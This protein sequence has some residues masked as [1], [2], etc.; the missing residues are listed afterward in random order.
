MSTLN[1]DKIFRAVSDEIAKLSRRV[2]RLER[3]TD[4][5]GKASLGGVAIEWTEDSTIRF[6]AF[7][8]MTLS[9]TAYNYGGGSVAW[10][11]NGT[12]DTS[13]FVLGS[14]DVLTGILSGS[15]GGGTVAL[16]RVA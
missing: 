1:F 14:G 4:L 6:R 9:I 7:E 2:R 8:A 11:V 10:D 15:T 5:V 16:K 13:P 12:G 3:A